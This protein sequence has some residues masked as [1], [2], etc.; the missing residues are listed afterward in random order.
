MNEQTAQIGDNL[1]PSPFEVIA[2]KINVLYEEAKQWLDGD[3]VASQGQADDLSNLKNMIR[4]AEKEADAL[5]KEEV[6]PFDDG[7]KAVQ[8]RYHPL[9]GNTKAGKGKTVLAIDMINKALIPWLNKLAEEKAEAERAARQKAE[10]ER[11]KADEATR[12]ARQA[13]ADLVAREQA[14]AQ[15]VAAQKA[16]AEAKRAEKD[17]A[18]ASGGIGRAS[19]LRSEFHPVLQNAMQA[20]AHYAAHR[21]QDVEQFLLGL[22]ATDVRNGAREIPGFEIIEEKKVV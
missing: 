12:S 8:E 15:L 13:E 17:T 9:I 20:L 16:E 14:E 5:R 18:K 19:H 2:D 22:A 1:P 11:R 7:K 6:K 4:D 3:P 21:P 10:E